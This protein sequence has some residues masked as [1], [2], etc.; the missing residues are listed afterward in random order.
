MEPILGY[1]TFGL[2]LTTTCYG[3]F[4]AG[5]KFQQNN[6]SANFCNKVHEKLDAKFDRFD[7]KLD[8]LSD[9]FS[10][11]EGKLGL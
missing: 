4:I 3:L 7:L 9:R 1:I 10:R 11:I 5:K 2:G 8:N 6:V